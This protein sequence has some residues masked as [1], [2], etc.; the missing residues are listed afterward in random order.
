MNNFDL[1]Q[2]RERAIMNRAMQL[3]QHYGCCNPMMNIAPLVDLVRQADALG[4]DVVPKDRN[5]QQQL[6][7]AHQPGKAHDT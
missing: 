5:L 2:E 6:L 4:F 7:A 3:A 1:Y